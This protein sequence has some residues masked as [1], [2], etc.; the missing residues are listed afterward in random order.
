MREIEEIRADFNEVDREIL[1]LVAKRTK[2]SF[3]IAKIKK[4]RKMNIVQLNQWK[5]VTKARLKENEKLG[6][7]SLFL[8]KLFNLLHEE[9]IRIQQQQI[10]GKK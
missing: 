9:S 6:V 7:D 8:L 3:E 4:Q 2:L 1:K 10:S 5:K